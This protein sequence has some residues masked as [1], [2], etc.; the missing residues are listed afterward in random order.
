MIVSANVKYQGFMENIEFYVYGIPGVFNAE[1][2]QSLT[3]CSDCLQ[4]IK[5]NKGKYNHTPLN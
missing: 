1:R 3:I 2:H 4:T 5:N